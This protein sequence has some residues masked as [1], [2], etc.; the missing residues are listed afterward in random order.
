MQDNPWKEFDDIRKSGNKR[1]LP[2]LAVTV[3]SQRS[4]L[5][6]TTPGKVS[7]MRIDDLWGVMTYLY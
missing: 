2:S 5:S 6:R 7:L 4:R 3:E 1:R